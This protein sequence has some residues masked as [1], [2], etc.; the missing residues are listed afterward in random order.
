MTFF[1]GRYGVRQ[2]R[3]QGAGLCR[4]GD[5]AVPLPLVDE[6]E[7]PKSPSDA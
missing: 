5:R 3:D 1:C 6:P 7:A 2:V 4:G